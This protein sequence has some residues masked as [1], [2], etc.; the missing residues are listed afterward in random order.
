M[1]TRL[2]IVVSEVLLFSLIGFVIYLLAIMAG[3]VGYH[4]GITNVMFDQVLLVLVLSGL[5]VFG[6]C[7]YL[8]C[9]KRSH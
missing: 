1:E 2:K 7:S 3:F 6:A 5:V 4:L 8:T 9:F